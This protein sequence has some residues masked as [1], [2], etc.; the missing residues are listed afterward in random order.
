MQVSYSG[1]AARGLERVAALSDG[2]FAIAMT[3]LV[4]EIHVPELPELT[5][6]G[7][8]WNGLLLLGPRFVTYLLSF[9]TLGIFWAGQQTQM[10][11]MARAD[12]DL[13]WIYVAFLAFIAIM[14]FTTS[15]LAEHISLRLALIIYWANIFV[16]GSIL[17]LAWVYARRA[18]LLKDEAGPE[19]DRAIRRRIGVAQ[20]LY[21]F[22]AALCL[23]NT[24]WSIAWIVLVQLNFATGPRIP[25]LRHI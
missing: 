1:I 9:L 21:A 22:G 20:A 4:L 3:L 6:D 16:L 17:Y 24:G 15:L 7:D 23:I 25:F 11:H 14:P 12:R 19:V 13:S 18:G 10:N 5:T 2:V 8:L